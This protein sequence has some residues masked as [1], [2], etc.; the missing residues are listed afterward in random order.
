MRNFLA[1][2]ALLTLCTSASANHYPD[3]DVVDEMAM[4]GR[5]VCVENATQEQGFCEV[6][7]DGER[8]WVAFTQDGILRWIRSNNPGGDYD[9]LYQ[10]VP[11]VD[12]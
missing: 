3:T 7:F 1:S 12:A 2:I 10:Y 9:Y 5:G 4:V 8:Y 11:G 6:Y